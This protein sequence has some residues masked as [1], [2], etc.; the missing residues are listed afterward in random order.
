MDDKI[1]ESVK[2]L[3]SFWNSPIYK[4]ASEFSE[5]IWKTWN[6]DDMV[7]GDGR[8]RLQILARCR[9]LF[10]EKPSDFDF[11]FA[12]GLVHEAVS[13]LAF[14]E[15][16]T[17]EGFSFG[18][19]LMRLPCEKDGPYSFLRAAAADILVHFPY[20][21]QEFLGKDSV[22]DEEFSVRWLYI[23]HSGI[24]RSAGRCLQYLNIHV[25]EEMP[26]RYFPAFH[27]ISVSP[28]R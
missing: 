13:M 18:L 28:F 22:L 20:D 24:A 7:A 11:S 1:P 23:L 27:P 12:V 15:Q 3:Q 9:D 8:K 16:I 5:T 17:R 4:K 25:P 2:D 26:P 10:Y 19:P 21:M 14:G 6:L